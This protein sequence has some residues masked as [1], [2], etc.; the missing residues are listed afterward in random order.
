M[1]DLARGPV[2]MKRWRCS[3]PASSS[4]SC[5]TPARSRHTRSA[6][7]AADLLAYCTKREATRHAK[8][9]ELARISEKLPGGYR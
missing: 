8:L 1:R 6:A 3:R 4:S 5:S 9:D 7:T 2:P